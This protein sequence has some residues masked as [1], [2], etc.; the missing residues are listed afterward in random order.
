MTLGVAEAAPLRMTCVSRTALSTRRPEPLSDDGGDLVL[1]QVA[2][3]L[4]RPLDQG[5]QL[6]VGEVTECRVDLLETGTRAEQGGQDLAGELLPFGF[7]QGQDFPGKGSDP[8][9]LHW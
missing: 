8:R 2:R 4:A 3:A 1:R 9:C 5:P 7:W 6:V